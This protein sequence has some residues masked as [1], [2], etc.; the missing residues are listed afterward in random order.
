[1][2]PLKS[3]RAT[4]YST[5]MEGAIDRVSDALTSADH[6]GRAIDERRFDLERSRMVM[7]SEDKEK[8]R[9]PRRE[10]ISIE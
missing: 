9:M 7:E 1:M 10:E 4:N 5:R 8:D 6:E 2:T 3:R